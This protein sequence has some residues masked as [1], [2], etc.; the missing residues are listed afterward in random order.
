[1]GILDALRVQRANQK[2]IRD[3]AALP[4]NEIIR[5]AQQG[6]IPADVVPVVLSEKA[7]MAQEIAGARASAQRPA[8]TVVEQ[9]M[10]ANAQNER[11]LAGLPTPDMFS[12]QSYA[13][14]GIVSFA[15]G[16]IADSGDTAD[17]IPDYAQVN[18]NTGE[19]YDTRSP[20][21][22][23]LSDLS[24]LFGADVQ[25]TPETLKYI[26]AAQK[27]SDLDQ[28]KWMRLLQAGLGIMGQTS[29]DFFTGVGKGSQEALSGY[30]SD[31]AAAKAQELAGLKAAAEASESTKK[32]KAEALKTAAT[33]A[34]A[35]EKA[36]SDAEIQADNYVKAMRANGD[37]R[38]DETIRQEFYDK[39]FKQKLEISGHGE[40]YGQMTPAQQ[41]A[42]EIKQAQLKNRIIQDVDKLMINWDSSAAGIAAMKYAKEKFPGDS[43]AQSEY[44]EQQKDQ[45]KQA[46]INER[47]TKESISNQMQPFVPSITG[48]F[49]ASGKEQTRKAASTPPATMSADYQNIGQQ[50]RQLRQQGKN[51]EADALTEQYF[52]V[53]SKQPSGAKETLVPPLTPSKDEGKV[54]VV[55]NP[56]TG[57][58]KKVQVINGQRVPIE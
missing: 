30:M 54:F 48:E 49:G 34:A 56:M 50:V 26:Q 58:K 3:L 41:A 9:A 5:M 25:P 17:K 20:E 45:A 39:L 21:E 51:A 35:T 23:R 52:G 40:T 18:P 55:R 16:G 37:E 12:E 47:M 32:S 2:S 53:G 6:T 1:M 11:G 13:G 28:Q 43:K 8:Q 44:V 57:E 29:P 22:I 7:R 33:Y 36:K 42:Y 27:P 19:I 15:G 24:R 10:Q 38:D 14:G 31:V 4:Q 46:K